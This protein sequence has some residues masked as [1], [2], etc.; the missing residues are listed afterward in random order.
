M[1][2]KI[3]A[4]AEVMDYV[5]ES[6]ELTEF[7]KDLDLHIVGQTTNG[8]KQDVLR[9]RFKRAS[10]TDMSEDIM[11][12]WNDAPCGS[13]PGL[14]TGYQFSIDTY[15]KDADFY[16]AMSVTNAGI[17]LWAGCVNEHTQVVV[18]IIDRNVELL[19]DDAIIFDEQITKAYDDP[20]E[21]DPEYLAYLNKELEKICSGDVSD[22]NDSVGSEIPF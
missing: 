22:V 19:I 14:N 9:I 20:A 11:D 6:D 4:D 13:G 7:G 17:V 12:A 16:G 10:P 3:D 18:K 15:Y 2:I 21:D 5:Y 1:N 8:K